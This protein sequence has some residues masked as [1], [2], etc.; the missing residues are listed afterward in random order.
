MQSD[1][2]ALAFSCAETIMG[3]RDTYQKVLLQACVIAGDEAKLAKALGV[4]VSDVVDWVLGAGQ[5]PN[6]VFLRAVDL[7]LGG[8]SARLTETRAMLDAIKR[9]RL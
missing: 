5:C 6:D 7:V 9:R 2:P 4:S 8:T 1:G 3:T